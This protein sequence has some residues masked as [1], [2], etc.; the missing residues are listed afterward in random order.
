MSANMAAEI[1]ED[2]SFEDGELSNLSSDEE[3][4]SIASLSEVED[5]PDRVSDETLSRLGT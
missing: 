3:Q 5:D 1:E 4:D 2:G